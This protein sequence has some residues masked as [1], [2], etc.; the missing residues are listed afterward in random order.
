VFHT[1]GTLS[2]TPDMNENPQIHLVNKDLI[3]QATLAFP[4]PKKE[5]KGELKRL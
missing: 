1:L 2:G 3:R 5:Y 4:V